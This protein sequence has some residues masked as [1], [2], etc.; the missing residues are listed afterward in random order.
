VLAQLAEIERKAA[1]AMVAQAE[2]PPQASPRVCTFVGIGHNGD[3]VAQK[4]QIQ[5]VI[6]AAKRPKTAEGVASSAWT[7]HVDPNSKAT[8]YYNSVTKE[9]S[10]VEPVGFVEQVADQSLA[11]AASQTGSGAN[12]SPWTA[13]TDPTSGHQYYYNSITKE[14]RWERPPD[15]D[16]PPKAAQVATPE[17]VS[18]ESSVISAPASSTCEVVTT[19]PN[20]QPAVA[21]GAPAATGESPWVVCTDHS[22]G[23]VYYFN[24]ITKA[25][26]WEQPADLGVDLAKPPPPPSKKPPPPPERASSSDNTVPNIGGWQEVKPEDSMWKPKDPN[27][28]DSED[29]QKAQDPLIAMKYLTMQRGAWMDEDYERRNKE[30]EIKAPAGGGGTVSFATRKK[31][32]GIR[33]KEDED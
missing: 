4:R 23:Y 11:S 8:Y 3:Q 6:A 27:D 19:S 5:E 21:S 30:M 9:S 25:S 28:P 17:T 13:C 31:A 20:P 1:A 16:D 24:K 15:F 10:W 12:G 26:S 2:P 14:S 18:M 32:S 22:T 29:E 7:K 33:K